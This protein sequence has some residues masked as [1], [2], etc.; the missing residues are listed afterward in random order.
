MSRIHKIHILF[1]AAAFSVLLIFGTVSAFAAEYEGTSNGDGTVTVKDTSSGSV[2]AELQVS[3][4]KVNPQLLV[5]KGKIY[6]TTYQPVS[7]YSDETICYLYSYDVKSGSYQ[8]L[9]KL[10]EPYFEFDVSSLYSGS[11][12]LSG[13][14]P[15]DD[16]AGFRY[17]LKSGNL[18]KI[19]E[20]ACAYRYRN[21]VVCETTMVHGSFVPYPLYVYNTKTGKAKTIFKNVAKYSASKKYLYIAKLKKLTYDPGSGATYQII[22]YNLLNGKKKILKKTFKGYWVNKITSKYVYHYKTSGDTTVYYRY[23]LKTGKNKKLSQAAYRK[24]VGF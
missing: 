13:W 4:A 14:N 21:Y 24:A 16:A 17:Y 6:F 3:R 5:S 8:N 1:A 23:S 9:K 20:G 7:A 10:N 19:A 18:K 11:L 2:Y 22:R 15:S 12:Y